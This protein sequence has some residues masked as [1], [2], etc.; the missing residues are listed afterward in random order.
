M[1]NFEKVIF[2][3]KLVKNKLNMKNITIRGSS[4]NK[5]DRIE[6]QVASLRKCDPV[7]MN[8]GYN[9]RI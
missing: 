6:K 5:D 7:G 1:G 2:K 4:L 3:L 8:N 9:D